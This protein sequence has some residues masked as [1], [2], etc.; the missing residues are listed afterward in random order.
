[1][2]NDATATIR[3]RVTIATLILN[4]VGGIIFVLVNIAIDEISAITFAAAI[5]AIGGAVLLVAYLYGWGYA[6]H[7]LIL[8]NTLLAAFEIQEPFLSQQFAVGIFIPPIIA[9]ILT[10]PAE[11]FLSMVTIYSILLIRAGGEGIYADGLAIIV[12]SVVI[13]GMMI[14][15]FTADALQRQVQENA[16]GAEAA[17]AEAEA[18]TREI[19]EATEQIEVRFDEQKSLLELVS[20]LETPVVPLADGLLLAPIIGHVDSRRA[21]AMTERLL[22][23]VHNQRA[24]T[25][26]IDITGVTVFGQEVVEALSETVRSLRLLGT[27]VVICG[28]RAEIASSMARLEITLD[29]NVKF[30]RT[31]QEALERYVPNLRERYV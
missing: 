10:G 16:K 18:R 13:A 19:E 2:H 5:S 15:R 8:L 22:H 9:M 7:S 29:D 25:I 1:M 4:I 31:P 24:Q 17:R 12:H 14:S 21:E 23:A 11:I 26:V 20:T 3:H 6:R 28:M 30:V 27:D